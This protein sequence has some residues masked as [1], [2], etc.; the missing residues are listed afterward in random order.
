MGHY[1]Y[2]SRVIQ[3]PKSDKW[4]VPN[5]ETITLAHDPIRRI[6]VWPDLVR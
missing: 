2:E 4:N 5:I 1:L 6:R 3:L